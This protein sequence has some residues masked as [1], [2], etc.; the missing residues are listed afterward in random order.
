MYAFILTR[1]PI[2]NLLIYAWQRV[3]NIHVRDIKMAL[4]FLIFNYDDMNQN[5]FSYLLIVPTF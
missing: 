2:T 1:I 5:E 4:K 3:F